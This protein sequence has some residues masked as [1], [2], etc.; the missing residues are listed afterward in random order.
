[1]C[2]L[3]NLSAGPAAILELSRA[4]TNAAGNVPAGNIYPDYE[5][6]VVRKGDDGAEIVMARWGM[7][8]PQFA[9]KG[10]KV[11]RGVTN[12]RNTAS[13][14]WR[15]WLGPASRCVVPANAFAEPGRDKDPE[16]GRIRNHWFALS[17]ARPLF[18]FAGVWTRWT[19]VRKL[20]EGEISVDLF[21][22]LTTEPNGVVGPIHQKA[23]PVILT[24]PD[25]IDT[26]L[27]APWEEASALQRPLSDERLIEIDSAPG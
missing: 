19:G 17:D 3:Y 12:V 11:D 18:V 20:K 24:E 16:T 21:G 23:M 8:S 10:K 15:R 13:P 7:P 25:E 1:M 9:L 26:W 5:A 4:M 2:N 27:N 6:P 14:H 22:F